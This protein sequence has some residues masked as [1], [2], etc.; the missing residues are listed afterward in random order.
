MNTTQFTYPPISPTPPIFTSKLPSTGLYPPSI[1]SQ[2]GAMYAQPTSSA[3]LVSSPAIQ[4]PISYFNSPPVV[5][6]QPSAI[7]ASVIIY[8]NLGCWYFC[9]SIGFKLLLF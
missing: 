7:L 9:Y 4:P 2:Q 1:I 8:L 5:A 3:L 6:Y